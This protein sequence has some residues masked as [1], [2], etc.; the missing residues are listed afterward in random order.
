MKIGKKA[1]F[2]LFTEGDAAWSKDQ[3]S[4][5]KLVKAMKKGNRMTVVGRSSRGTK[6][7]DTYSL[8]GFTAMKKRIDR[9]CK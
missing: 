6:T 5:L 1:V 4:D 8:S 3:P 2:K 7:T 9:E